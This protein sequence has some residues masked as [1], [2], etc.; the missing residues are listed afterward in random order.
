MRSALMALVVTTFLGG[1]AAVGPPSADD[2]AEMGWNPAALVLFHADHARPVVP[3]A[4]LDTVSV[5]WRRV[6]P[7]D[8]A[9]IE[10]MISPFLK[11]NVHGAALL[12]VENRTCTVYAVVPTHDMTPEL[13]IF[14]HELLHCFLGA[15]HGPAHLPVPSPADVRAFRDRIDRELGFS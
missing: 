5:T 15:F 10:A 2:I 6:T 9:R 13:A 14:G 11:L 3:T 12:D 4:D 7:A 8:L 1:C